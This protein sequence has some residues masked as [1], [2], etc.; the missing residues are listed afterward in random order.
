MKKYY[1]VDFDEKGNAVLG[2]PKNTPTSNGFIPTTWAPGG[3]EGKQG[4][5]SISISPAITTTPALD[6]VAPIYYDD[7]TE[8]EKQSKD[9]T[10]VVKYDEETVPSDSY[11]ITFKP[12]TDW[13]A[14]EN[15]VFGEKGE[16]VTINTET[17]DGETFYANVL[18][19]NGTT[20]ETTTEYFALTIT[21]EKNGGG[22]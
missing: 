22:E 11:Q 10:R 6:S 17:A 15:M 20:Q 5:K 13:Y 18:L 19:S 8:Q 14:A 1:P 3:D 16:A 4:L 9:I 12:T 2:T 7:L 21:I